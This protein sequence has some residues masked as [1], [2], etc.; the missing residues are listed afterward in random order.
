MQYDNAEHRRESGEQRHYLTSLFL[1]FIAH[2]FVLT[3]LFFVLFAN[4]VFG[5]IVN[6]E[7]NRI[8]DD[9][10]GWSGAV[11]GMFS[12][13]KNKDLLLSAN[14]RPKIQYKTKKH[15]IFL[16]GDYNFS[17]GSE[18][19]FSNAGM[20]HLRYA[21]RIKQTPWKLEVYS[22]VQYNQ[23]LDLRYRFL[24]GA[25]VRVKFINKEKW[26][27]YAGTSTF[28]ER[29]LFA[30]SNTVVDDLRWSNYLSWFIEPRDYFSFTAAT[31][32]QPLWDDFSN[33]RVSGQYTLSFKITT[34]FSVKTELNFF[35]DEKAQPDVPK[36]IYATT[37]GFGY[38]FK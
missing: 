23:L 21:Y 32:Y 25:G 10:V 38:T 24:N 18:R 26:K 35:R 5:Q 16:V 36:M 15:N 28:Y 31:Y 6:I 3:S 11:T 20:F 30:A 9:S 12:A 29:Q 22:Q 2:N 14:L 33:Y 13:Q 7:S 37:V 19:I 17:K 34:Q 27:L 4:S 1:H 8:H